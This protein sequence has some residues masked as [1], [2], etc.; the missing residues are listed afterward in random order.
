ML[1]SISSVAILLVGS[2]YAQPRG[3]GARGSLRATTDGR[4]LMEMKNGGGNGGDNGQGDALVE[5]HTCEPDPDKAREWVDAVGYP[6][7]G[8]MECYDDPVNAC[9]GGCCRYGTYFICDSVRLKAKE[10]I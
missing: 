4:K 3:A 6:E 1:L 8:N 10:Q 9:G 2:A 5:V 7:Q